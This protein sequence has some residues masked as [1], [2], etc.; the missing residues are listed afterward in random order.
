VA[1]Q[2]PSGLRPARRLARASTVE[3]SLLSR[4]REMNDVDLVESMREYR[5]RTY[6]DNAPAMHRQRLSVQTPDISKRALRRCRLTP[7]LCPLS[8]LLSNYQVFSRLRNGP[9][10]IKVA[11]GVFV[12]AGTILESQESCS[13]QMPANESPVKLNAQFYRRGPLTCRVQRVQ[14]FAET[15][16]MSRG[17]DAKR[18]KLR[19]RDKGSSQV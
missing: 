17:C 11:C 13:S 18:R 5:A 19:G 9:L 15:A 3:L 10:S 7:H 16:G 6:V 8:L 2:Q 4:A 1:R 12:A 14:S